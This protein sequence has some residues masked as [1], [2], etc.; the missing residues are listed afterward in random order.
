[1]TRKGQAREAGHSVKIRFIAGSENFRRLNVACGI[2]KACA[3]TAGF[4]TVSK[5][6]VPSKAFYFVAALNFDL[7]TGSDLFPIEFN[8]VALPPDTGFGFFRFNGLL[9]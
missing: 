6:A 5:C 1:M 2:Y 4:Q 7:D 3:S 9:L 8:Q